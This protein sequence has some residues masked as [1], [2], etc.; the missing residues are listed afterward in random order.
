VSVTGTRAT[1]SGLSLPALNAGRLQ[2]VQVDDA[3]YVDGS[4]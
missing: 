3:W 4:V 1:V 2:F